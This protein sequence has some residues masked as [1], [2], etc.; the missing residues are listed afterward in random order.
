MERGTGHARRRVRRRLSAVAADPSALEPLTVAL[1]CAA[2]LV[3]GWVDAVSGGGGLVQLPA[4]LLAMPGQPPAV[5]LGTNK[6][7]AVL[8]TS[9]AAVTYLRRATPDLRTAVPMAVAAFVGS[10]LGATVAT[11]VPPGAFRPVVL[12]LLVVAWLWTLLRPALG[13]EEARRFT[14]RRHYAL[15]VAGGAVIGTYDGMLGPGTGSFL[16]FLLVAGLG[17]SFLRASATAKVVNVG[18]N[19]AALIVFGVSGSVLWGLGLLMGAANV[20]GAVIGA[21]TAVARGSG[22]VRVVFLAV[23]GVLIARLGWDVLAG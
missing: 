16:V 5:A 3:A 22:F 2:A 15:A 14:G 7:S 19:L 17:Y 11:R 10:A 12:V 6:L 18:T 1:L 9:A 23:V 4:L 21:R 13:E 8:G 20:L